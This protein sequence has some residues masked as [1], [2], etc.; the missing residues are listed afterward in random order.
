MIKDLVVQITSSYGWYIRLHAVTG[1]SII[2]AIILIPKTGL[3]SYLT[4]PPLTVLVE[5]LIG[6]FVGTIY[7]MT[8]LQDL[9]EFD[10]WLQGSKK[11]S[12]CPEYIEQL[13]RGPA[14]HEVFNN[15]T[16]LIL[17]A[18]IFLSGSVTYSLVWHEIELFRAL[19]EYSFHLLRATIV[20]TVTFF[21]GVLYARMLFLRSARLT[22]D[23]GHAA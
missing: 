8:D 9:T 15:I 2:A 7:Y 21:I 16:V 18:I 10:L 22:I 11:M 23:K 19:T 17:F 12:E 5:T 6:F 13:R 14:L 1:I 3:L 4:G 20:C